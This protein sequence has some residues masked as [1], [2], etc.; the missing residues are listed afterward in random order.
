MYELLGFDDD[1]GG[2]WSQGAVAT[3]DKEEDAIKYI[4]DS[5]GESVNNHE[6]KGP[7]HPLSLLFGSWFAKVEDM[8]EDRPHNPEKNWK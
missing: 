6:W 8:D 4:V 2:Y 5:G 1:M 3:F 7:F